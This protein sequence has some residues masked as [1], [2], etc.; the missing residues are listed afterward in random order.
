MPE[1]ELHVCPTAQKRVEVYRDNSGDP[2]GVLTVSPGMGLHGLRAS[3][4]YIHGSPEEW[5]D[6]R[7]QEWLKE[8]AMTRLVDDNPARIVWCKDA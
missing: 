8:A 1:T 4:L 6:E 3:M 7:S 5:E 2:A